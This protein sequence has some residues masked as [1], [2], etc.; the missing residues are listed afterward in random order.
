MQTD[1]E[2]FPPD[3]EAYNP[4]LPPQS[5]AAYPEERPSEAI[6]IFRKATISQIFNLSAEL[7]KTTSPHTVR[8]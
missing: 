8:Y 3:S 7:E 1:L 2:P 6:A 5:S 4:G